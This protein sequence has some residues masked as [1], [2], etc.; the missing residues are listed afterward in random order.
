MHFPTEEELARLSTDPIIDEA[1]AE[2]L[3]LV[4]VVEIRELPSLLQRSVHG[5]QT[6]ARNKV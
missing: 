1:V 5:A 3:N 4:P 6:R 2:L